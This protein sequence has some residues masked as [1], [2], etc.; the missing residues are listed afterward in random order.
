[1]EKTPQQFISIWNDPNE[2]WWYR[3]IDIL[4]GTLSHQIVCQYQI[5]RIEVDDHY[6]YEITYTGEGLFDLTANYVT[7]INKVLDSWSIYTDHVAPPKI[8]LS[9]IETDLQSDGGDVTLEYKT[10]LK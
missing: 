10:T 9:D 6:E 2:I 7:H 1:M 3:L 5:Q 8:T 4:D